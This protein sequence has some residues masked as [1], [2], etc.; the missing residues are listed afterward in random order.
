MRWKVAILGATG[1]VGQRFIQLLQ[2]HPWFEIKVVAASEKNV[3]KEYR[4]ACNWILESEIP[5]EI[6]EMN[7]VNLDV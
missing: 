5:R 2:N 3:G 4:E 6:A 7:I 1:A